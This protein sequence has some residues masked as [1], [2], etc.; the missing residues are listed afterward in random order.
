MTPLSRILSSFFAWLSTTNKYFRWRAAG[1]GDITEC[2]SNAVSISHM[3]FTQLRP[4][5]HGCRL[6]SPSALQ[7]TMR[8]KAEVYGHRHAAAYKQLPQVSQLLPCKMCC[9]SMNLVT[10]ICGFSNDK[11]GVIHDLELWR[12]L[13]HYVCLNY[14]TNT[15]NNTSTNTNTNNNTYIGVY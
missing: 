6:H 13:S 1:G 3:L 12:P 9:P 8:S 7:W 11:V 14:I 10:S 2:S 4:T 5:Q 15:T